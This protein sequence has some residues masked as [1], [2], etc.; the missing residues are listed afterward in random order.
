MF[1]RQQKLQCWREGAASKALSLPRNA[2]ICVLVVVYATLMIKVNGE[3]QTFR[4][5]NQTM[6]AECSKPQ[7]PELKLHLALAGA[8][9]L[10][11][12]IQ[13]SLW[14]HT[15]VEMGEKCV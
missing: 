14:Q 1:V 2:L 13:F 12:Q 3:S 10:N 11:S 9:S 8:D 6:N 7:S 4:E 5:E 15:Q